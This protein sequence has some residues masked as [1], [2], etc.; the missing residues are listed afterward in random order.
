MIVNKNSDLLKCFLSGN[1]VQSSLN[2]MSK[3]R[4][5]FRSKRPRSLQ[6]S[7][8][9]Y[10]NISAHLEGSTSDLRHGIVH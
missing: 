2:F 6:L 3:F 4:R 9:F 8:E 1:V 10:L 7:R 5:L